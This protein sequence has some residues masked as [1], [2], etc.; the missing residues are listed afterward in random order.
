MARSRTGQFH[1]IL[2]LRAYLRGLAV[3]IL[4]FLIHHHGYSWLSKISS[5]KCHVP[6]FVIFFVKIHSMGIPQ[7]TVIIKIISRLFHFLI[8]IIQ[9]YAYLHLSLS[10]CQNLNK[11]MKLVFR[12]KGYRWKESFVAKS[13]HVKL[14][15]L[16]T[17]FS[18][19]TVCLRSDLLII[20]S[21]YVI[22]SVFFNDLFQYSLQ[23]KRNDQK[24]SRATLN[25]HELKTN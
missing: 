25:S 13:N 12:P 10:L 7:G 20:R 1:P 2:P 22:T 6:N 23:Q 11:V 4:L 3:V 24:K 21:E 15:N 5:F 9:R 17:L 18:F 8:N 16:A 14:S 19:V